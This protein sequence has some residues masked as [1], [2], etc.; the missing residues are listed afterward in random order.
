MSVANVRFGIL[1]IL[2]L[3]ITPVFCQTTNEQGNS[4][5]TNSGRDLFYQGTLDGKAAAEGN[6][7]YACG[8]FACGVFGVIAAAVSDPEPNAYTVNSLLETKGS[9]YVNAYTTAYTKKARSQNLT[10]SLIGWG[11]EIVLATIY[12]VAVYSAASDPYYKAPDKIG[13]SIPIVTPLS[14][15]TSNR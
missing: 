3:T 9:D 13:I 7:L 8:G 14:H 15:N 4:N 10:Y 11:A 1:L 2:C 12:Y 5:A 6:M